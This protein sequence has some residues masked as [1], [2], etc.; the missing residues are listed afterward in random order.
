MSGKTIE[1]DF[2]GYYRDEIL[3][4]VPDTSGIYCVYRGTRNITEKPVTVNI[5]ELIYIGESKDVK[6]RLNNH[7]K[8]DSWKNKL[9]KGEVLLYSVAKVTSGEDD[10]LRAEAALINHCNPVVN[11]EYTKEYSAEQPF[12][13]SR[14]TVTTKNKNSD[15]PKLITI[16]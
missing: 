14:T 11:K 5:F 12:P 8:Y 1:L 9:K 2:D 4:R 6:A 7:D 15:L 10:R 13:F 16:G 3:S